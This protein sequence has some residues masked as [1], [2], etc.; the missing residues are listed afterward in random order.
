MDAGFRIGIELEILLTHRKK[1]KDEFPD[2]EA[3][4]N[5]LIA[6]FHAA[7][8]PYP[9]VH[10]DVDGIYEGSEISAEWSL[11]DDVTIKPDTDDQYQ[12]R[13]SSCLPSFNT[14]RE[15]YG[16][17]KFATCSELSLCPWSLDTLKSICRSIFYFEGAILAIVP[18]HR[19]SNAYTA[20]NRCDN[21]R[22]KGKSVR[23][24]LSILDG[25]ENHVEIVDLMNDNGRRY[26]AW[27]FTNLYYGGKAT[28]EFRQAP[29]ASDETACLP[30][31]EFVAS[32][33]NSSKMMSSD[34]NISRFSRDVQGLRRFL[35]S[36]GVSG[37]NR[38][39]LESLFRGKSGYINPSPVRALVTAEQETLKAKEDEG[40]AKNLVMKKLQSM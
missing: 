22:L 27:N 12:G 8:R 34:R 28:L 6:H 9:R 7:R 39:I 13:W 4:A 10:N 14:M 11:T 15:V 2:L 31:V 29:G 1:A 21:S 19:R 30:W 37:S 17:M 26:F 18:D 3:F 5:H 35:T 20:S 16:V 38:G 33:V 40:N 25:C 32:F 36:F 23:E 24:C